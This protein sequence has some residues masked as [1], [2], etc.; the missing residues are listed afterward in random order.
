MR[1]PSHTRNGTVVAGGGLGSK[2]VKRWMTPANKFGYALHQN[3]CGMNGQTEELFLGHEG[4]KLLISEPH[5]V[6]ILGLHVLN[7][8]AGFL[9]S[10]R[11]CQVV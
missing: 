6:A 5:N 11:L 1:V 2:K 9:G 7:G 10:S 3:R 4:G 8:Q